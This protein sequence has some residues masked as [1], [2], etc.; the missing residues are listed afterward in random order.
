MRIKEHFY[1]HGK[2]LLRV[3]SENLFWFPMAAVTNFH[4]LG[5]LKQHKCISLQFWKSEVKKG[6]TGLKS[7]C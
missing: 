4:K 2:C 3:L 5:G 7:T 6:L 1:G